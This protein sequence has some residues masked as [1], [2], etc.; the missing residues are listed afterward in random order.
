MKTVFPQTS[1][2]I[3]LTRR[4][5]LVEH[6]ILERRTWVEKISAVVPMSTVI[7]FVW[8]GTHGIKE[9]FLPMWAI[10]IVC[11]LLQH[12]IVTCKEGCQYEHRNAYRISSNILPRNCMRRG[13]GAGQCSD[14]NPKCDQKHCHLHVSKDYNLADMEGID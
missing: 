9:T 10:S 12:S 13:G 14:D 1:H 2:W 6:L 4:M 11:S 8:L 7:T 3:T 5:H